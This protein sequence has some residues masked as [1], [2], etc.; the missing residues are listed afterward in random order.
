[1]SMKRIL[2]FA[3][4][5]CLVLLTSCTYSVDEHALISDKLGVDVSSGEIRVYNDTHGGF[6]GDG[7]AYAEIVFPDDAFCEA[8]SS[9]TEWLPLPLSR[10]LS[11]AVYGGT[12]RNGES[13]SSLIK[14]KNDELLIP[15]ITAGYYFFTDRHSESKDEKDDSLIF[16]RYSLNFT[17]A[18][19]DP[20]TRTLY[21]YAIDT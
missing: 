17:L 3:I 14:D 1:M 12:I 13:R 8:L 9:S 5:I 18:I 19:Y 4:V 20:S 6:L 10:N 11:V 2:S 16:E 7:E 21:F 15:E